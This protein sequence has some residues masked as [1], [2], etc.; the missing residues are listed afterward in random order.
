MAKKSIVIYLP[1]RELKFS[2]VDLG[3]TTINLVQYIEEVRSN[4][5]QVVITNVDGDQTIYKGLPY[6]LDV[7]DK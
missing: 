3:D 1:N 7:W 4:V 5:P 6:A 2:T